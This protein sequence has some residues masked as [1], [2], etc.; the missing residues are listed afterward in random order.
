VKRIRKR[1]V[2][3]RPEEDGNLGPLWNV[4]SYGDGGGVSEEKEDV[5]RESFFPM[6]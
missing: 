5:A 1:H 2:V 4:R 3:V 6:K